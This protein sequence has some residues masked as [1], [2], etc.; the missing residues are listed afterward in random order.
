MASSLCFSW[1]SPHVCKMAAIVEVVIFLHTHIHKQVTGAVRII[2]QG[3]LECLFPFIREKKMSHKFSSRFSLRSHWSELSHMAVPSCK[4][5]WEMDKVER[6]VDSTWVAT[7][8]SVTDNRERVSHEVKEEGFKEKV[9]VSSTECCWGSS[10][11]QTEKCS[12]NRMTGSSVTKA[13]P[14]SVPR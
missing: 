14:A 3:L 13:R 11:R 2:K 5:C 4:L 1:T 10:K 8:V 9:V 7:T 12:S 6:V